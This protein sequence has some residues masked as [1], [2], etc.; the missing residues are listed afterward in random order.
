MKPVEKVTLEIVDGYLMVRTYGSQFQRG[1]TA[2]E[3]VKFV[4]GKAIPGMRKHAIA[5]AKLLG[6]PFE[7]KIA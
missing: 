3:V 6:V 4:N 1:Y 2:G 7:D 5:K